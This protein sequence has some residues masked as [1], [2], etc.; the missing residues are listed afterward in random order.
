MLYGVGYSKEYGTHKVFENDDTTEFFTAILLNVP[1]TKS[2]LTT[3]LVF[4]PYVKLSD[5]S[6][7]YGAKIETSVLDVAVSLWFDADTSEEVKTYARSVLDIC[8]FDESDVY[9]SI[10]DLWS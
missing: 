5:G 4:R 6:I 3:A 8:E 2:A 7:L 1:N 9:I 10:D